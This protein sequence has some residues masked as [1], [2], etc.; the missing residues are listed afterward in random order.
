VIPFKFHATINRIGGLA[1][2]Q[3]SDANQT[4]SELVSRTSAFPEVVWST[5]TPLIEEA[6]ARLFQNLFVGIA[7]AV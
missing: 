3:L 6:W 7:R 4:Y 2:S 1:S 5:D